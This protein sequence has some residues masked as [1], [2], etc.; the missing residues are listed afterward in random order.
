ML[1]KF[2]EKC[3]RAW[4]KGQTAEKDMETDE[5]MEPAVDFRGYAFLIVDDMEG[6]LYQS[7]N[8]LLK[9][10]ATVEYAGDGIQAVSMFNNS[11]EGYYKAIL[12]DIN[13]P[14]MDGI[15]ITKYIRNSQRKDAGIII[16]SLSDTGS[17]MLLKYYKENGIHD[18]LEK[19]L[20]L[21]ILKE[22]LEQLAEMGTCASVV[23]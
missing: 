4:E 23:E 22:K 3:R 11:A 12:T 6:E 7:R 20:N 2:I 13:M 17:P 21:Y 9:S 1:Q 15:Q 19:P 16:M 8:I 14:V 10:G 18:N 5:T